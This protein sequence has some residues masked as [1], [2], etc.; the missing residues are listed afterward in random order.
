MGSNCLQAPIEDWKEFFRHPNHQVQ[1]KLCLHRNRDFSLQA[2]ARFKV[3]EIN[4][5]IVHS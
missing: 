3:G 4:S 5:D 1:E 2:T